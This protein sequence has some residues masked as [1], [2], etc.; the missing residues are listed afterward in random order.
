MEWGHPHEIL[1]VTVFPLLSSPTQKEVGS[2]LAALLSF[3]IIL[4]THGNFN[5]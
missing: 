2:E 5:V 1:N 3:V 4:Y